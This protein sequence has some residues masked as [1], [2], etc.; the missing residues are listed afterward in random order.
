MVP[1][2]RHPRGRLRE[3]EGRKQTSATPWNWERNPE[4]VP[5]TSEERGAGTLSRGSAP[6]PCAGET[7]RVA[8][9]VRKREPV[10]QRR[11]EGGTWRSRALRALRGSTGVP[12][13][14]AAEKPQGGPGAS[15][16]RTRSEPPMARG[17]PTSSTVAP[18]ASARG[19]GASANRG[20]GRPAGEQ[21][22][23]R[24]LASNA[25]N[26]RNR[27][28]LRSRW[29]R[30]R[31]TQP[32]LGGFGGSEISARRCGRGA[33]GPEPPC[34]RFSPGFHPRRRGRAREEAPGFQLGGGAT[35]RPSP[36]PRRAA[37]GVK[38]EGVSR[39]KV[40]PGGR[41]C[42]VHRGGAEIPRSFSGTRREGQGMNEP[43]G[44]GGREEKQGGF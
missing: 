21:P 4:L 3:L 27:R 8:G 9:R 12:R 28:E 13:G 25:E 2:R 32:V 33:F 39:C 1:A 17:V 16:G 30:C 18:G 19:C 22:G 37:Q 10:A 38:F 20:G 5:K 29:P 23:G 15:A 11:Q 40:L 26:W 44:A 43:S 41:A 42:L 14:C 7:P 34:S 31:G 35:R 24:I 36:S 6:S